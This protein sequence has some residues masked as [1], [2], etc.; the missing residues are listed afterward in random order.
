MDCVFTVRD[1]CHE[2]YKN[3]LRFVVFS[4]TQWRERFHVHSFLYKNIIYKNIEAGICEIL[5][6]F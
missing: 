6:I 2:I 1:C 3:V 4:D 5:R